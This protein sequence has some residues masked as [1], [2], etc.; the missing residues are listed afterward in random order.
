M[1]TEVTKELPVTVELEDLCK[2]V[3]M[4]QE[5]MLAIC[6]GRKRDAF[7]IAHSILNNNDA[8]ITANAGKEATLL[9]M[10]EFRQSAILT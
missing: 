9:L 1:A 6:E 3:N 4:A 8:L 7:D 5:V 10:D 2:N